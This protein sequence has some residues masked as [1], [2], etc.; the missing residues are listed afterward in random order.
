MERPQIGCGFDEIQD[1]CFT[2]ESFFSI[3]K[4]VV[5]DRRG[6]ITVSGQFKGKDNWYY[7]EFFEKGQEGTSTYN[8]D[9]FSMVLPTSSGL[10]FTTLEGQQE[11]ANI[12]EATPKHIFEQEFD[13][14]P[15]QAQNSVFPKEDIDAAITGTFTLN[16]QTFQ[17]VNLNGP[18]AP[19]TYI[20]G[21]D[22]GKTRDNTA[23]NVM[24]RETGI[25]VYTQTLPLGQKYEMQAQHV[26]VLAQRWNNALVVIDSTGK[27]AGGYGS[28]NDAHVKFFRQFIPNLKEVNFTGTN[29][30]IIVNTAVL[31]FQQNKI[32]IP[33]ENKTLIDQ[34]REYEYKYSNGYFSYNAP[35]NKHD[36][37]VSALLLCIWGRHN[38][39]G[40]QSKGSGNGYAGV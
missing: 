17:N 29:K 13:C 22:I 39:W 35:D 34:L 8:K 32:H 21:V 3:I 4:P 14:I 28:S 10:M 1:K 27:A 18:R 37:S 38:K 20:L 6:G 26:K 24:E 30:P 31:E 7:K 2:E 11:L 5:A 23:I 15:N 16:G 33:K 36:D 12:K 40:E 9:Y 19:Y 25:T